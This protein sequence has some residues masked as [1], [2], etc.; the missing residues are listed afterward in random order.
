MCLITKQKKPQTAQ[1]NITC[2]KVLR[3]NMHSLVHSDFEW[4]LGKLYETQMRIRDYLSITVQ[5]G[6]HSYPSYKEL[7]KEY[8]DTNIPCVMVECTI[9]KGALYYDGSHNNRKGYTSNQLIINKII[10]AKEVFAD[11]PWDE[12]PYKEGQALKVFRSGIEWIDKIVNIQPNKDE[13]TSKYIGAFLLTE[14]E[15]ALGHVLSTDMCGLDP[16]D[17]IIR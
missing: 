9:P 1:E 12:Y 5:E 13:R 17:N 8:F 10:D 15:L 11:F 4:E 14:D 7:G 2:Y 16:W 3:K 6:F